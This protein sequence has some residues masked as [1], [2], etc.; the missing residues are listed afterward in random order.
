MEGILAE[1]DCLCTIHARMCRRLK[2]GEFQEIKHWQ[3]RFVPPVM[4]STH[5]KEKVSFVNNR[6]WLF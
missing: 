5:Q 2:C 3:E 4:T 6:K 1:A